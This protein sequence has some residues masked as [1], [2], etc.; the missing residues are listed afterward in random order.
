MSFINAAA[1]YYIGMRPNNKNIIFISQIREASLEVIKLLGGNK[2][3]LLGL[4]AEVVSSATDDK[5]L[6][7]KLRQILKKLG[8]NNNRLLV[9]LPRQRVTSRYLKVPTQIPK[10]LDGIVSLQAARYLPYP[11]NELITAYQVTSFDKEGCSEVNLV[12]VHK[13]IIEYYLNILRGLNIRNFRIIMSSYG[14]SNLYSYIAPEEH[15]PRMVVEAVSGYIEVAV[16]LDDR[17]LFSRGFKIAQNLENW[18]NLFIEEINR[19]KNAYSKEILNKTI[20][21]V[22]IFTS[23]TTLR[24]NLELLSRQINLPVEIIS[25][26]DKITAK[27]PLLKSA[28]DKDGSFA[29]L[30]GLGLKALPNSLNL[31]PA[32]LKEINKKISRQKEALRLI[33]FSLSIFLIFA[34]A[35]ARSLENKAIYLKQLKIESEKLEKEAKPLAEMENKIKFMAERLY[36]TPSTLDIIYELH[37]AASKQISLINFTY[38]KDKQIL[39]RGQASEL[40]A[41]NDF[42][43]QL[44]KSPVFKDFNIKLRYATYRKT[45]QGEIVD[46]EIIGAKK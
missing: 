32:A 23:L 16:V 20:E 36:S 44:E 41:V 33:L 31:E 38:E 4:E 34:S 15:T 39:L 12:I 17:L 19:T 27:E 45:M 8:Y 10:E 2:P 35:V 7:Q 26:W 18:Q 9:A 13:D 28:L 6:I 24:D 30:I 21:K 25:Y 14:L 22:I 46:F 29:V 42:V 5:E 11:A 3:E 1:E 43:L 37:Q 40:N